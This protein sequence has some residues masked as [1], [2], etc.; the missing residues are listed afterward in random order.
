MKVTRVN[1]HGIPIVK[2]LCVEHRPKHAKGR[3][4][5]AKAA[6]D[7]WRCNGEEDPNG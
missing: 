2:Q 6:S 5:Y 7:C 1:Q 4:V 3:Q